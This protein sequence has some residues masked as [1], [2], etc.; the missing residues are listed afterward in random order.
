MTRTPAEQHE[1]GA[2]VHLS[3]VSGPAEL[4]AAILALVV[5]PLT[6]P[7]L[8]AWNAE[9]DRISSAEAL[10]ID[11]GYLSDAARLPC[12]EVLLARMRLQPKADRRALLQSTRR[13]M[14]THSPL[15]PIDRLHWL[16][17]RRGLGD[18]PPAAAAPGSHN[19]LAQLPAGTLLQV[20]RVSAYLSRMVPGL[21][22][23]AAQAWYAEAMGRFLPREM[24]PPCNAPDGD[25]LANALEEVESLPWMLRPVLVRAWVDA[26]IAT[27]QRARLPAG[28]ADALR[29][30]ADLLDSPLP[31]ELSRHFMELEWTV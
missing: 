4:Q 14:A 13:L 30:A 12:L 29:L 16:A 15:R 17:M 21:D 1:H 6:G 26:A 19:D 8:I 31:P 2:L 20:A 24:V 18:R 23:S 11:V 5:Q 27:S 7:A 10:L 3:H 9:N 25:G 28:A 22:A